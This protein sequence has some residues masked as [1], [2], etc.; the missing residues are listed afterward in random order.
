MMRAE[1][2]D[3]ATK[4]ELNNLRNHIFALNDRWWRDLK[5]G[6]WIENPNKGEKLMLIVSEVSEMMEGARKSTM[7]DHLPH[8]RTEEVEAADVLIRLLDYCG[9]FGLD[10]GGAV[11]E[12]L[13]YNQTRKDHTPEARLAAGG[14]AF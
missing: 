7:D 11:A 10:I 13:R 6:A 4:N 8:R 9:R 14:K 3:L 1:A 2:A 5:T 12:K